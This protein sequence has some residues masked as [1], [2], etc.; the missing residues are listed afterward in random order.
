MDFMIACMLVTAELSMDDGGS[1][2]IGPTPELTHMLV[3][4]WPLRGSEFKG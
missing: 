4:C 1:F 3:G 2:Q